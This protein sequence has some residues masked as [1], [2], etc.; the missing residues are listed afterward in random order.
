MAH[1]E[2][3]FTRIQRQSQISHL[4]ETTAEYT[5]IYLSEL[6]YKNAGEKKLNKEVVKSKSL[7]VL[8]AAYQLKPKNKQKEPTTT[9]RMGLVGTNK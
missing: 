4:F 5:V 2:F 3:S 9:T 7:R 1:T 6:N 8:C